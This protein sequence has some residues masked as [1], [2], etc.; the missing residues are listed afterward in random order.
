[1]WTTIPKWGKPSVCKYVQGDTNNHAI[2]SEDP[3]SRVYLCITCLCVLRC[4][5]PKEEAVCAGQQVP[6]MGESAGA[7]SLGG[8]TNR[9]NG[10]WMLGNKP[11][12][13][14]PS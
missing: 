3:S 5:D 4:P 9:A 10:A 6:A 1:M 11:N 14:S 7:E 8:L 2:D 13:A 12:T